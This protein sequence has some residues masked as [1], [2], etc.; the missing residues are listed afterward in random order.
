[1]RTKRRRKLSLLSAFYFMAT[2]GLMVGGSIWLD[3][4]G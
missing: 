4:R 3:D 2:L 1:M